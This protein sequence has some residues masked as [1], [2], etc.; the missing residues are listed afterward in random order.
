MRPDPVVEFCLGLGAIVVALA[1]ALL[2]AF[3]P[4]WMDHRQAAGANFASVN[5]L[6][7]GSNVSDHGV[8]WGTV[9]SLE[10]KGSYVRVHMKLKPGFTLAP[11][12]ALALED[13]NPVQA[14]SLVVLRQCKL[15]PNAV[16]PEGCCPDRIAA[17][18]S[19]A[20][21]KGLASCGH[22]PSLIDTAMATVLQT[23]TQLAEVARNFG[24][25]NTAFRATMPPL[26][27][28][29]NAALLAT[30]SGMGAMKNVSE[31]AKGVLAANGE[32]LKGTLANADATLGNLKKTTAD[33]NE[34]LDKEKDDLKASI[35]NFSN[36]LATTAATM[37][38]VVDHIQE[39]AENLRAIT[40]EIRQEP[41]SIV[42][43]RER[44]D[45]SFVDPA[46]EK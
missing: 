26:M 45:P 12:Q 13:T 40:G 10:P 4:A 2:L 14:A 3:P 43:R 23:K 22:L 7:E 5:H 28:K 6:A 21:E 38:G 17:S 42:R 24:D 32:H 33:V 35:T 37:P 27:D 15:Q 19:D 44:S 1:V 16:P 25:L 8:V 9:T 11:D 30:T 46:P 34:V 41:T 39:S 20:N 18:S 31:Y 29:T 36:V